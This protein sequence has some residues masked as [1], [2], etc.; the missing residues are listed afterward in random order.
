MC[1]YFS[2]LL[3]AG[4]IDFIVDPSFQVMGDMLD[5]ILVPM[6]QKR[7][8]DEDDDESA[9]RK[10]SRATNTGSVD[11]LKSAESVPGAVRAATGPQVPDVCFSDMFL[12]HVLC[13]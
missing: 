1:I 4:F 7:S 13:N 12:L 3:I 2:F 8:E 9:V 6:Q 5:K 11:S 10:V